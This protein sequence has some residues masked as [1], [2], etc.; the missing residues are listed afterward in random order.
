MAT[1][2]NTT[3]AGLGYA[4]QRDR[5]RAIAAMPDGTPCPFGYCGHAPMYRD[6]ARNYDGR[7]LHYDHVIARALGGP[8]YGGLMRLAHATCNIKA[9]QA[10][11]KPRPRRPR[12]QR[13]TRW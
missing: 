9:G 6:P 10:H 3:A 1:Q 13:Y 8:L 2:G 11:R 5:K 4:H 12:R 7:V